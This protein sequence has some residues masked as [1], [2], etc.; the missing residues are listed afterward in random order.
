MSR[1]PPMDP[2]DLEAEMVLSIEAIEVLID[3]CLDNDTDRGHA[4]LPVL[5]DCLKSAATRLHTAYNRL[6]DDVSGASHATRADPPALG[7]GADDADTEQNL[8][9]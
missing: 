3:L 6:I 5:H 1:Q 7:K 9:C 4:R 8:E 2:V